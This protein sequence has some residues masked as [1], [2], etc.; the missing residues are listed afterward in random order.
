MNLYLSH[1]RLRE[2]PFQITP[3][4]EFFFRG[5]V[6]GE[7]LDALR[8]ALSNNAGILAVTGEVGT[9]K[10]MMCR[11]LMESIE[12]DVS[13]IYIANPSLSGRELL[14]NI[15]EELDLEVNLDKPHMVRQLQN[16]L[17]EEHSQ[18]RRV[19]VFID[20]A[21]AM[22]DDSLE[23]IRLLSNLETGRDKLLQIVM[24]GQ[25]ELTEKITQKKMRQLRERITS[26]FDLKPFGREEIVMYIDSR[27]R[28]AGYAGERRIFTPEAC[29]LIWQVSEGILRR[30]NI[31]CDKSLLAAFARGEQGVSSHHV[32]MAARDAGYNRLTTNIVQRSRSPYRAAAA[33]VLVAVLC[34]SVWKYGQFGERLGAGQGA[35]SA[36]LVRSIEP[37]G[38][39]AAATDPSAPATDRSEVYKLLEGTSTLFE[40]VQ[41]RIADAPV[42]LSPTEKPG[43]TVPLQSS[44]GPQAA[45]GGLPDLDALIAG[46]KAARDPSAQMPSL[47][48][49]APVSAIDNPSWRWMPANSF[50]RRRL[51]ATELLFGARP[52]SF[53]TARL[54][55]VV[56]SRAMHIESFLRQLSTLYP[57]RN[58]MVY[59]T[60]V[61]GTSK[62]VVT[63]GLF[64]TELE[65]AAFVQHMPSYI[66]GS[67]PHAQEL[68]RSQFESAR[69]W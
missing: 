64:E 51:N 38:D 27:L 2:P 58:I 14:Y 9:G 11:T 8:Y 36:T 68:V 41:G 26:H 65:A 25:P 43:V 61:D 69:A 20:E 47:L 1:F 57:V 13:I 24:F 50:L 67:R 48:E 23:E 31:L 49:D 42:L 59:P 34:G 55:T 7:I 19:I 52:R 15:V 37:D 29:Q 6:R 62:F 63:Y 33:G 35:T 10:T 21:Q 5:G 28:S 18:R 54:M 17:I 4:T 46:I 30:V 40:N 39:R 16:Y 45:G 44:G 32:Q 53:H 3:T 56:Q 66:K 60:T 22:P 12:E